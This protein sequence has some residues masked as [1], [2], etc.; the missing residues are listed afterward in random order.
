MSGDVVGHAR[1]VSMGCDLGE[2]P[3]IYRDVIPNILCRVMS[4]QVLLIAGGGDET[5]D[6]MV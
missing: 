2:A 6:W 4:G 5:G 1:P 3:G